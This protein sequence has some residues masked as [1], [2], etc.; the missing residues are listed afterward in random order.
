VTGH[1]SSAAEKILNSE[2]CAYFT[3]R[4]ETK[5][6]G[7]AGDK[8]TGDKSSSYDK[9]ASDATNSEAWRRF[10][11]RKVLEHYREVV[12]ERRLKK[13]AER[14]SEDGK[15]GSNTS[16]CARFKSSIGKLP[17]IRSQINS[18]AG[19]KQEKQSCYDVKEEE[20]FEILDATDLWENRMEDHEKRTERPN[21]IMHAHLNDTVTNALITVLN[22][23]ENRPSPLFPQLDGEGRGLLQSKL[24]ELNS[25]SSRFGG[26]IK[27]IKAEQ[28]SWR[29]ERSE[30]KAKDQQEKAKKRL[31]EKIDKTTTC[32]AHFSG[33]C[34]GISG[35]SAFSIIACKDKNGNFS[36][37][38]LNFG[39]AD[40]CPFI[41][42]HASW[43]W[44]ATFF[45]GLGIMTLLFLRDICCGESDD[46]L[47]W[48]LSCGAIGGDVELEEAAV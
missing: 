6:Q 13:S 5:V 14:E 22:R 47:L 28:A 46:T 30:Q 43:I 25:H 8:S 10:S 37:A 44:A 19:K 39:S 33:I 23:E 35:C 32:C 3:F 42:E 38:T 1:E 31:K 41:T 20:F 34:Y 21:K 18:T 15:N 45:F 29:K 2:E 40:Q 4:E 26:E 24:E 11:F 48:C 16:C 12:A 9:D 7:A 36:L 27:A 17:V